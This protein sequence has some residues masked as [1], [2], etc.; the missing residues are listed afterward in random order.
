[1]KR[2]PPKGPQKIHNLVFARIYRSTTLRQWT[3]RL[4]KFFGVK[5]FQARS[6]I[7]QPFICHL[8]DFIGEGPFINADSS[9]PEILIMAAWCDQF[10]RPVVFDVGGNVGFVATQTAL[11][12]MDKSPSV[13]S[14]EPVPFT[15]RR[16]VDSVQRL[17]L[18]DY[19]H[20]ICTAMSAAPGL[21]QISYFE[22]NTML[23]QVFK[24]EPNKRVGDKVAF[25]SVLTIDQTAAA[26]NALP[27]LIKVD[28]EGHEVEVFKGAKLTL[29]QPEAPGICFELNPL[30]LSE[31]FT[32]VVELVQLFRGYQFFYVN[33]FEGQR[34]EFGETITCID[35]IDWVCNIFAVPTTET[36]LNRWRAALHC[37]TA[38][39][40]A[41]R[42]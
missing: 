2:V 42:N 10:E 18:E 35:D 29:S 23:A 7:N 20:P 34:M 15:F 9:R 36:A 12:L 5:Q 14:F 32:T 24:D 30:T 28:V 17:E 27:C 25:S 11:L 4:L 16:L 13:Y 41:L 8:G 26:M 3:I 39:L 37:A 22:A 40:A 6:G 31:S 21:T 19:V 33:D 38:E 1:M